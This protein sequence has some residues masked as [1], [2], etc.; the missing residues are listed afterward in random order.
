MQTQAPGDRVEQVGVLD[1][2]GD[3]LGDV[4]GEEV[5][6]REDV[7]V[8]GVADD[9]EDK[10]GNG[11]EVEDASGDGRVAPRVRCGHGG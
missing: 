4:E 5:D 6:V 2:D 1:G 3:D 8:V 10:E 9:D 7:V 11:D